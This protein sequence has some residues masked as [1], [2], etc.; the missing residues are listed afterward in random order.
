[1]F[2]EF[3]ALYAPIIGAGPEYQGHVPVET[4]EFTMNRTV[5][6]KAEYEELK[7]DL[8]EE[9]NQVDVKM[10]HPALD[11][12]DSLQLLKKTIKKREDKKL[13]FERYQSRHDAL[14]KKTKN[15]SA[16]DDPHFLKSRDD[17]LLATDA[18]SAA[19]ENLRATLPR[20]LTTV[21][22]LLPHLLAAQIQIQNSLLAHYYTQIASYC[23]EENFPNPSPPMDEVIRFWEDAFKPV[24]RDAESIGM[25]A[26]GKAVRQS[27][28][29]EPNGHGHANGHNTL[30]RPSNQSYSR[31]TS[32]SPARALPPSPN[33]DVK[34]PRISPSPSPSTTSLLALTPSDPL[35]TPS[36]TSAHTPGLQSFSPAGPTAD[37]FSRD[38]QASSSGTPLSV[39]SAISSKKK[40]PP[41]PPPP[42]VPSQQHLFVTALYDF[43]GQ[44]EGDL[45]F[46]E[47]DRIRIVKKTESTDDWW[48]GELRGVRGAFPANYCQ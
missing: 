24:Q 40:P 46:K 2:S 33:Y 32:V 3:E 17:L 4:P 13:D 12:K 25:L 21:F 30:R 28:S 6:I 47:G 9:V 48:Q 15:P 36:S 35:P 39:L 41:P 38:R 42:R 11:A 7:T 29:L 34:P 26:S 8:T 45:I 43:D 27:M 20:L 16:R 10:I 19:D 18:Y 44:G 1:M 5:R 31:G 22:S 37:Y 23:T 14:L